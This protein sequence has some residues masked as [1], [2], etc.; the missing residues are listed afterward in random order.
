MFDERG[1][2][3]HANN[4]YKAYLPETDPLFS[5]S[6]IIHSVPVPWLHTSKDATPTLG[7]VISTIPTTELGKF[8]E[9]LHLNYS[10]TK[11]RKRNVVIIYC[12]LPCSHHPSMTVVRVYTVRVPSP[13]E[14]APT[15][16]QPKMT[17]M[18]DTMHTLQQVAVSISKSTL[19]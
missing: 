17:L 4:M 15:C 2:Q 16:T 1:E 11:K 7:L 8:V 14:T 18:S 3:W 5:Y 13:S 9:E 19:T 10:Q 12:P 6:S